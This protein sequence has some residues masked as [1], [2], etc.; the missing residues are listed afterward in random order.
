MEHNKTFMP[1]SKGEVLKDSQ[2]FETLMWL[3]NG[4]KFD[5]VTCTNYEINNCTFYRKSL[6][7]KSTIYN[8]G[9]S[10]EAELL[11]FSTSKEQNMVIEL[12][13][14]YGV[15]EEIWEVDYTMF[16]IPLFKCK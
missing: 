10:L 15:I 12:M 5:V 9:V 16:T 6:D 7:D 1:W 3:A 14:Y 13:T 4:L 11:Q 2:S 8:S